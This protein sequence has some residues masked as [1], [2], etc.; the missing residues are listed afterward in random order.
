MDIDLLAALA[1][2]G[3]DLHAIRRPTLPPPASQYRGANALSIAAC[4]LRG[5]SSI[6]SPYIKIIDFLLQQGCR[7]PDGP[8]LST[9]VGYEHPFA[10]AVGSGHVG[11]TQQ[12]LARL[13][14][15]TDARDQRL[16]DDGLLTAGRMAGPVLVAMLIEAGSDVNRRIVQ[17]DCTTRS[18]E[19]SLRAMGGQH[20]GHEQVIQLILA[21]RARQALGAALMQAH[22][23]PFQPACIKP[24]AAP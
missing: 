2:A 13:A 6:Y 14:P 18:L 23:A 22:P 21:A 19:Q 10:C 11:L 5:L 17:P 12:E 1:N 3:A 7:L 16:I 15:A 24:K 4:A 8:V 20:Q 9:A